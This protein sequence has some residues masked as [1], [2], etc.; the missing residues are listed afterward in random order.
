MKIHSSHLRNALRAVVGYYPGTSFVGDEVQIDAPYYPL[1]HHKDALA[2]YR[3]NQPVSHNAEYASTTAKH[4][5]AL[6]EFL[7]KTYGQQIEE[8]ENRHNRGIPTATFDLLWLL[9]RPG[10]VIYTS[11]DH[12][13]TPFVIS[14]VFKKTSASPDGQYGYNVDC[15]S[16]KY[17]DRHLKRCM[18]SFDIPPFSGEEAINNL[19][20]VPARF[21]TGPDGDKTPEEVTAEHIRQGKAVWE[22]CKAPTY[23]AYDGEMAKKSPFLGWDYSV[24]PTGYMNG[25]VMIDPEGYER[26]Y[27]ACPLARNRNRFGHPP[28]PR[29]AV[30][31]DQ[32]PHFDPRCGCAVCQQEDD[33]TILSSWTAFQNLD[34]HIDPAPKSDVYYH[35]MQKVVAGFVLGDRRW[36]H[37]HIDNLRDIKFDKEAF[38]YLVLEDDIKTTLRALI[39]KFASKDGHVSAWPNDFVKNKGQGR[40]FLLHGSPGVGKT[41]TAECV[42][43]LTHRPLI[44][45]TSGDLSTHSSHVER[46]LEYFLQLGERFGAMVLLDEADVYLETRRAKDIA[47]NGLVSVFLRALEYYRGVLFLTTNR[48]QT[49]DAAFTSR[50]HVALHYGPLTDTDRE[51]IWTNSFQRLEKDAG[52]R[53]QVTVT[54]REYAWGSADVRSLRWNGREIRNALQTAVALAESEALDDGSETIIV[55]DTHLRAVVRMSRGFKNFL[56]RNIRDDE[57]EGCDIIVDDGND[58]DDDEDNGVEEEEET[59]N[60]TSRLPMHIPL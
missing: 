8:E 22:F 9:M 48:V 35:V 20:A 19:C 3:F 46:N 41:C 15:W 45:L 21:F 7:D 31:D 56:R 26:Y 4:I 13:W 2:R 60:L 37:F 53:V 34:P 29:P 38:K 27:A 25:R 40:I 30:P 16:F 18:H 58:E 55:A 51:R 57:S 33:Q 39:G 32:L 10:E 12:T 23:H 50:I 14:R 36:G 59:A 1:F 44:S 24:C 17:V 52:G 43:E 47:R 42:A 11:H 28:P 6:L 5:D 49:F 54:A